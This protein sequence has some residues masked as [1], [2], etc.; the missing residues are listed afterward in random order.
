MR[1]LAW[2]FRTKDTTFIGWKVLD[3]MVGGGS[4]LTYVPLMTIFLQE[5]DE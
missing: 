5:M 1:V 2:I 3:P 4:L